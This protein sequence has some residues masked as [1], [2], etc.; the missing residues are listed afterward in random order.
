VA[1]ETSVGYEVA[2]QGEDI[3]VDPGKVEL[4]VKAAVLDGA[5]L[6]NMAI[7]KT[8]AT[9]NITDTIDSTKITLDDVTV[10]EGDSF[11]YSAS[12]KEAP[13][14]SDLVITLNNGVEITIAVGEKTGVSESQTAPPKINDSVIFTETLSIATATGGNYEAIDKSDTLTLSITDTVPTLAFTNSIGST[15]AAG[16]VYTGQWTKTDSLD[17]GSTLSINLASVQV[18]GQPVTS[19]T[20]NSPSVPG[21]VTGTFTFTP[22]NGTEQTVAFTLVVNTDGTYT[23]TVGASTEVTIDPTEFKSAVSASGPT[24]TYL[25]TYVDA[26][27]GTPQT[28]TVAAVAAGTPISLEGYGGQDY[29]AT[30]VGTSINAS[31]DGI[32]IDNNVISSYVGRGNVLTTESLVY[33][34]GSDADAVTLFFKGTGSVGFGVAGAADVLYITLT[35]TGASESQTIMLDSRHGDFLVGQDGEL[36]GIT[37]GY[38]GGPLTSYSVATPEGWAGIDNVKVTAGF[39]TTD[40]GVITGSD[41]KLAFG[42]TTTETVTTD[43]PV[44]LNFT[45]ILEDGDGS[46]TAV[47]N[48]MVQTDADHTFDGTDQSDYITGTA[49]NDTLIGGAGND[50]LTGDTG[51]DVFKWSLTDQGS[52]TIK[53]FNQSG[54]SLIW[55]EGDKLD[56]SDLLTDVDVN[57]LDSYFHIADSGAG[58]VVEYSASGHVST[59]SDITITLEGLTINDLGTSANLMDQ[60]NKLQGNPDPV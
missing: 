38:S 43:L 25:I 31:S 14:D 4:S 26:E 24:S 19:T 45:A 50:T 35:G 46:M 30:A 16:G 6:E 27:S 12:V 53:D 3:Y 1:G 32:G 10:V 17:P 37:G 20:V 34:P 42:F 41:V 54:G 28:A 11:V 51:A 49:G 39:F 7:D 58:L 13:E 59:A 23:A 2:A 9:V 21:T 47:Q 22:V 33:T 40:K 48:F 56:L 36:T 52:D 55:K 15:S 60:L 29:T 57:S 18:N 5:E 8:V 44:Q